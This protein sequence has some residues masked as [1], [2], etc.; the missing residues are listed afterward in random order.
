MELSANLPFPFRPRLRFRKQGINLFVHFPPW[1]FFG[2]PCVFPPSFKPPDI[3]GIKNLF[4]SACLSANRAR[5]VLFLFPLLIRRT[6][7]GLLTP[8]TVLQV[9]AAFSPELTLPSLFNQFCEMPGNN[10][11]LSSFLCEALSP[12]PRCV[13]AALN[14]NPPTISPL[15]RNLTP[16]KIT[17]LPPF[18]RPFTCFPPNH[19]PNECTTLSFIPPQETSGTYHPPPPPGHSFR[20]RQ[21]VFPKRVGLPDTIL[22]P[23]PSFRWPTG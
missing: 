4:K 18:Y 16:M 13:A 10:H 6:P 7:Q 14:K 2:T 17:W 15:P 20:M 3:Q 23:S 9:D 21:H 19:F 22:S 8:I 12:P 5:P 11:I 1:Y